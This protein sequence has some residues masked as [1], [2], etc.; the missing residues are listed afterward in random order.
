MQTTELNYADT[1]YKK[2]TGAFSSAHRQQQE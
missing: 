2:V 1:I